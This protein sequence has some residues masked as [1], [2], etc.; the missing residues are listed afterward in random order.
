MFQYCHFVLLLIAE[1]LWMYVLGKS[2]L[3]NQDKLGETITSGLVDQERRVI[4][5]ACMLSRDAGM[6]QLFH[7]VHDSVVELIVV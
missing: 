3:I 1:F 2:K 5:L 7:S 6:Y 4:Q